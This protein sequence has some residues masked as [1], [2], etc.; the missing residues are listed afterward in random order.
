MS[1]TSGQVAAGA[2]TTEQAGAVYYADG[3]EGSSSENGAAAADVSD[4]ASG[5]TSVAAATDSAAQPAAATATSVPTATPTPTATPVPTETPAPAVP[6]RSDFA[7]D[8]NNQNWNYDQTAEK[9]VYLTFDDGP[10]YLTPQVLDILDS[11]GIKATFFVT[12]Q[13]PDYFGL[14]KEA[15]ICICRCFF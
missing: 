14:I 11:Y 5:D 8:P 10:S 4:T 7:V 9:T 12:A 2:A 15:Y 13:N 6:D 1:S 3:T